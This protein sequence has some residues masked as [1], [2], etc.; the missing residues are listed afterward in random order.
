MNP[1]NN[2]PTQ[3]EAADL[4]TIN[5]QQCTYMQQQDKKIAY[6]NQALEHLNNHIHVLSTIPE[7][8]PT[9]AAIT[10]PCPQSLFRM[11][12]VKPITFFGSFHSKP[13]HEIQNLLNNYLKCSYEIC[14]L[15]SFAPSAS[16]MSQLNQP[17]FIQFASSGLS[18]N[19]CIAWHQIDKND[20]ALMTWK[21][22]AIWI[23][24]TFGSILTSDQALDA[25]DNLHQTTSA[26]IY[27][28]K[29]NELVSAIS[30]ANINYS[31]KYLCS[32]YHRGLK[33]HLCATPD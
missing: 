12:S 5:A 8:P 23:Q 16:Q 15:Y 17:T 3:P 7:V 19:A 20:H 28:A 25:M 11:L 2:E 10:A 21:T 29:F 6:L 13:A 31:Q 33:P 14:I 22:Y 9:K 18:K 27:S 1:D 24:S 30:T 26:I 4:Q 32:H